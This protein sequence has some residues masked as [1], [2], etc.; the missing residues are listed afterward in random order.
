MGLQEGLDLAVLERLGDL[1][2]PPGVATGSAPVATPGGRQRLHRRLGLFVRAADAQGVPG[3]VK[4]PVLS[5]VVG[6]YKLLLRARADGDA[7]ILSALFEPALY[8]LEISIFELPFNLLVV[9]AA[10]LLLFRHSPLVFRGAPV[11]GRPL[12]P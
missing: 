7:E 1:T 10:G 4:T 8:A 3:S 11:P 12:C 5:V 2:P 9:R 6:V